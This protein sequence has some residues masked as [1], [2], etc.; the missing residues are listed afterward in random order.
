MKVSVVTIC[1]NA[2][3]LIED[4]IL[5][6]LNQTY[7]D[8]E[9]IIIDGGSTDG[10]VNSIKRYAD[11]LAYWISEPDEG[12]YDAM[13]KGIAVATG[14]YINFMNAGDSFYDKDVVNTIF[15]KS[16]M[17]PDVIYG[18]VEICY[19]WGQYIKK[20]RQFNGKEWRLPFSHQSSFVKLTLLKST[21]FDTFYRFAADHN[22]MYNLFKHKCK[23]EHVPIV[24]AKYDAYGTSNYNL[25]SYKEVARINDYRGL[26]YYYGFL[27]RLFKIYCNK[28]VPSVLVDSYR[29]LKRR[30][31]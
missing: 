4:T 18:D 3:D 22:M 16:D 29:R 7:N 10:T 30:H 21:P 8:L 31:R 5:S 15:D 12:I 6:V 26:K 2:A 14:D 28:F 1:Y 20:G 25:E 19:T 9:Y 17:L 24:V 13:N 11:R 27:N 23:F